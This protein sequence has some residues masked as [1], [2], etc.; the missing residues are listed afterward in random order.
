MALQASLTQDELR[1][2]VTAAVAGHWKFLLVQGLLLEL[3]GLLA[4]TM[5]LWSTLA[6]EIFVGWLFLGGGIVR[7]VTLLRAPHLP[8][9]WWSLLAAIVAM[10][11]GLLL[12]ISPFRGILA[13]T[14]MLMVLFLFEGFAAILSALDF[15][16]HARNWGWLLFSGL[17]DLL[18][19]FLIWDGW[20]GTAGWAIG[21]L[22]GV[23][24]FMMGLA[25]VML[26]IAV[27]QKSTPA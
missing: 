23:N 21:V 7:A 12:I 26:S 19:V 13:L 17:V 3:L 27:R 9:Y 2:R 11:V 22:T 4:F 18:L 20:P 8:G 14:M 10:V 15:R 16:H 6:V 25:L 1:E 24:L 5:P